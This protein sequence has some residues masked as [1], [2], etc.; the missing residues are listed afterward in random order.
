MLTFVGEGYNAAFIANY[1]RI[2]GRL[3]AG[4]EI[5]IVSGPDDICAPL[6]AGSAPH[7]LL[8]GPAARDEAA[9]L[10]VGRML[11]TPILQGSRIH[12]DERLLRSLRRN[13]AADTIRNAC[14]DCEWSELCS[15]VARTGFVG[16]LVFPSSS[17]AERA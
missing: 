1:R 4:E 9:A 13:F 10:A 5:E 16:A 6:L 11:G 8:A 7:C 14:E 2:A 3:S 12:P 17:P 15:T